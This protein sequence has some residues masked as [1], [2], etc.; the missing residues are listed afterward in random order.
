MSDAAICP[1]CDLCQ[2][3]DGAERAMNACTVCALELGL[4][5]MA[6]SRRPPVPCVRCNG[7]R[8]VRALPREHTGVGLRFDVPTT[9]PNVLRSVS[10]PAVVTHEPQTTWKLDGRGRQAVPVDIRSGFG[11]LEMFICRGCGFVEWYCADPEAIPI[12]PHY[13]T[14]DI[15]YSGQTPYR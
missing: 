1:L 9:T 11:R 3:R 8:F 5:P 14:E 15:D 12:G 2:L 10:A 13:L 4:V 6:H 7:M